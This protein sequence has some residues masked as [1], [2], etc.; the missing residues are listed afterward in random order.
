MLSG[1]LAMSGLKRMRAPDGIPR[2]ENDVSPHQRVIL[3]RTERAWV[4]LLEVL[5]VL[6]A[7]DR[8]RMA[9]DPERHLDEEF[10]DGLFLACRGLV[11]WACREVRT[12]YS[13]RPSLDHTGAYL[14]PDSSIVRLL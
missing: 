6:H 1:S 10:L 11:E 7:A 9:P 3:L 14:R 5:K 8:C 13:T 12:E 4:V 2:P